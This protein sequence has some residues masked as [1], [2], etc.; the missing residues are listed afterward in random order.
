MMG[1]AVAAAPLIAAEDPTAAAGIVAA[2]AAYNYAK[3]IVNK[4]TAQNGAAPTADQI[5]G[6]LQ[7]GLALS[8]EAGATTAEKAAQITTSISTIAAIAAAANKP[9]AA[10]VV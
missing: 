4:L 7:A 6:G 2:N 9:L 10:P 5:A 1:C 3:P 8:V